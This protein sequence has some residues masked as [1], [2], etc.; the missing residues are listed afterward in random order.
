LQVCVTTNPTSTIMCTIKCGH[1][2]WSRS[3]IWFA[4]KS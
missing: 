1:C 3:N 4:E 2:I